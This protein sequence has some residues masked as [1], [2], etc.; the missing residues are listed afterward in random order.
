MLLIQLSIHLQQQQ[1]EVFCMT[2]RKTMKK[3]I[4]K[5]KSVMGP[6]TDADIKKILPYK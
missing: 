2:N 5:Q 6:M 1:Q 3:N 4:Q